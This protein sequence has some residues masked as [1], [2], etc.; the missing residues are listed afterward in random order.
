MCL[1]PIIH[2]TFFGRVGADNTVY[3]GNIQNIYWNIGFA[4]AQQG[5]LDIKVLVSP[6]QNFRVKGIA[7]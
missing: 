7:Q 6:T 4:L 3:I 5:F 2:Q 1:K